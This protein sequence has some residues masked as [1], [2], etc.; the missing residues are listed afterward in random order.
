M[1]V[2]MAVLNMATVFNAVTG[3]MLDNGSYAQQGFFCHHEIPD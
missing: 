3:S 1:K 2:S